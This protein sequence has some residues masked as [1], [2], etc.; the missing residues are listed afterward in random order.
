[1]KS[2]GKTPK[3]SD[4]DFKADLSLTRKDMAA[5]EKK[6]F[7]KEPDFDG[8]IDFLEEIS[9]FESEKLKTE[10]YEAESEL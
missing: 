6:P 4:I 8:Y 1:M 5:M 2:S 7:E 10:F 3:N 9:A